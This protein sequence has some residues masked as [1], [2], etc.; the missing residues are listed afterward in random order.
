MSPQLKQT[1]R[2]VLLGYALLYKLHFHVIFHVMSTVSTLPEKQKHKSVI[3]LK[4]ILD[5]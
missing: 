5:C 1:N 2:C 4:V 3:N